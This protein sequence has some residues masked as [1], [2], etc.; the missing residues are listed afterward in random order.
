MFKISSISLLPL[1]PV[2]ASS[3]SSSSSSSV[4]HLSLFVAVHG[5]RLAAQN[6]NHSLAGWQRKHYPPSVRPIQRATTHG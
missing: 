5:K 6:F 4:A 3:S 2:S 1:R